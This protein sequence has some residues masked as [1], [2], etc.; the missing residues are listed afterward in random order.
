LID[1]IYLILTYGLGDFQRGQVHQLVK[2]NTDRWWHQFPDVWIVTGQDSAFWRDQIT[3]V[4]PSGGR[5]GSV[6][7]VEAGGKWSSYGTHEQFDWLEE[8][9]DLVPPAPAK[10]LPKPKSRA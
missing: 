10:A 3:E 6:L 5:Q 2:S 7:V 4:L 9:W 1:N 8:T